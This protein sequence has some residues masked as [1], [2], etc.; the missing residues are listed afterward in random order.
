MLPGLDGVEVCRRLRADRRWMPVLML[1]ARNSIED[2][3]VGLDAGADDYLTKPFSFAELSARIRA[4]I[5]RGNGERPSRLMVADLRLD[6][7]TRRVWRGDVEVELSAKE[8]GLLELFLRHPDQVL[9]RTQILE[10]VW[11]FAYDAGSNIV[12][13]YVLYLRRK[14]D[15]PFGVRQL[16]TVRGVGYRLCAQSVRDD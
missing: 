10:H 6:P 4:L 13:Q 7:A 16:E 3:V 2:R 12:D 1:T 14:V 15:R 8:F 5:R 11:D 9:T